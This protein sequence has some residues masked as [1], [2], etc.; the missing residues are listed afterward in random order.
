MGL[1]EKEEEDAIDVFAMPGWKSLVDQLED[2]LDLCNIDACNTLED[3]HFT[4]GR[5]AVLRMI[6]GYEHYVRQ[7]GEQEEQDYELQ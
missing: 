1:T 2:Q 4:K 3:L 7:L 5:A 6:I